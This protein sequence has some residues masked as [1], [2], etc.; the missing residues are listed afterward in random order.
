MGNSLF[1]PTQVIFLPTQGQG[2]ILLEIRGFPRVCLGTAVSNDKESNEKL[3]Q[4]YY[5]KDH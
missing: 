1:L 2:G 3:Q 5:R 4:L